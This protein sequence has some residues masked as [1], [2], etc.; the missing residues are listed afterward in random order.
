[1]DADQN[2]GMWSHF[3]PV[4]EEL[5]ASTFPPVLVGGYGLFLKQEWIAE[6][7]DPSNPSMVPI[8]RWRKTNPR[9]TADYDMAVDV[10]LIKPAGDNPDPQKEIVGILKN[11]GF[12]YEHE[13][14]VEYIRED[15]G[16]N[17][18]V[19][20]CRLSF[21]HDP[22]DEEIFE[23][24]SRD[25]PEFVS[26]NADYTVTMSEEKWRWVKSVAGN[27]IVVK[28]EFMSFGFRDKPPGVKQSSK[29]VRRRN[30]GK[31]FIETH[32][33]EELKG[34]EVHDGGQ[35]EFQIRGA[36]IVVPNPMTWAV[37]KLNASGEKYEQ[38]NRGDA[39]WI[40]AQKQPPTGKKRDWLGEQAKKHAQDLWRIIALTTRDESDA[41][42]GELK[43]AVQ[44][45]LKYKSAKT[46]LTQ[47][48]VPEDG[49][50]GRAGSEDWEPNDV[51]T[52][53]DMLTRW[54]D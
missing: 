15:H 16:G 40:N 43:S 32:L 28:S 24:L 2:R 54:F 20:R 22:T 6:G 50:G 49:F 30:S 23:K 42:S 38:A 11:H 31:N 48:F 14:T 26:G 12:E 29:R 27:E 51:S 53:Q 33:H 17:A 41:I 7:G 47:L 8:D 34:W 10:N 36:N 1:M 35:F 5:R 13:A 9:V 46:A 44:K 3:V 4:W 52:M 39:D 18:E 19:N 37:M 21:D 25:Q 45:G